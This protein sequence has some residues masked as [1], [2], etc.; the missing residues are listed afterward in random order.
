MLRPIISRIT[1]QRLSLPRREMTSKLFKQWHD[2][3]AGGMEKAVPMMSGEVRKLAQEVQ[4]TQKSHDAPAATALY[5]Q[6]LQNCNRPEDVQAANSPAVLQHLGSSWGEREP[7]A[8]INWIPNVPA[9][10]LRE[11]FIQSLANSWT[12]QD[13]AKASQWVAGLPAGR[14]KDAAVLGMLG[15]IGGSDPEAAFVWAAQIGNADKRETGYAEVIQSLHK[16]SPEAAK[17]ALETAPIS[18]KRKAELREALK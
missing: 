5:L 9:G 14:E 8:A 17:T 3:D 4:L 15:T 13:A 16:K 10:E 11:E 18:E 2:S 7:D 12:N 1:T 6:Q